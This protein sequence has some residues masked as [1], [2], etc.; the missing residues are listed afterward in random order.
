LGLWLLLIWAVEKI[1][2]KITVPITVGSDAG[3]SEVVEVA[4]VKRSTLQADTLGLS[5]AKARSILARLGQSLFPFRQTTPGS[6]RTEGS[7]ANG[8]PS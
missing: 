6:L 4:S 8:V 3:E 1:G 7:S 5:L 2:M